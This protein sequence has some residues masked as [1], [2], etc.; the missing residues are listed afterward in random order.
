MKT[1]PPIVAN[2]LAA[3][4]AC[5]AAPITTTAAPVFR[6][7]GVLHSSV[8][9]LS[10]D[11]STV[12]GTRSVPGGYEAFRWTLTTGVQCLGFA[13]SVA[14]ALSADGSVVVGSGWDGIL[15]SDGGADIIQQAFRW[16]TQPRVE[17]QPLG[18]LPLLSAAGASRDRSVARGVTDG[19]GGGST[20][21]I[22]YASGISADG[23]IVTGYS[24]NYAFRWTADTGLQ[25]L[26]QGVSSSAATAISHDGSTIVGNV[27]ANSGSPQEAFRWTAAN[28]YEQLGFLPSVSASRYSYANAVSRDGS[29]IAGISE[30]GGHARAVQWN[31]ARVIEDLG[32]L[33][34]DLKSGA[35]AVSDD[36]STVVG[37]SSTEGPGYHEAAFLWN[38]SAGMRSL[39]DILVNACGLDL[40]GWTLLNAEGISADGLTIVGNGLNPAGQSE[41]WIAVLPEPAALA[42]LIAIAALTARGRRRLP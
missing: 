7:L 13:P 31:A 28:G 21:A 37:S 2:M 36:G 39:Q 30:A 33:P 11:G 24:G 15:T 3:V 14:S 25:P 38:A 27:V 19:G 4:T 17:A 20:Y 22:S 9:A 29:T 35:Y 40:Q 34:G 1:R 42:P 32:V 16:T 8:Y 5:A 18:V 23:S 10:G 41:A 12:V 26:F 6:G